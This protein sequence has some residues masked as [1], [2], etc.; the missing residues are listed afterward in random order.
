[1]GMCCVPSTSVSM[2]TGCSARGTLSLWISSLLRSFLLYQQRSWSLAA[3]R[4]LLAFPPVSGLF[5]HPVLPAEDAELSNYVE[6]L[7]CETVCVGYEEVQAGSCQVLNVLTFF[8]CWTIKP[9]YSRQHFHPRLYAALPFTQH[10]KACSG[11]LRFLSLASVPE[12]I[13]IWASQ[14]CHQQNSTTV[15][16]GRGNE[17]VAC[18]SCQPVWPRAACG[19]ELCLCIGCPRVTAAG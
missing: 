5:F 1:M 19:F 18:S 2:N 9:F 6:G 7:W 15:L 17:H 4:G 16:R 14:Q 3:A 8:L 13:L 12:A 11:D 10:T